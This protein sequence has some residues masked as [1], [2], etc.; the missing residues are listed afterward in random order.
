MGSASDLGELI[1]GFYAL[2]EGVLPPTPG[3]EQS[4]REFNELNIPAAECRIGGKAFLSLS[5]GLGGQSSATLMSA[6]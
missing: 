5:H 6:P 2:E 1:L 4:D 3:F